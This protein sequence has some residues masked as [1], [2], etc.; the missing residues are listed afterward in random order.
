MFPVSVVNPIRKRAHFCNVLLPMNQ[1][2]YFFDFKRYVFFI[3]P[4]TVVLMFTKKT[5][6]PSQAHYSN[7]FS[8]QEN[9]FFYMNLNHG[10][11]P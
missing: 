4:G 2:N 10:N 1:K 3:N 8:F 11:Q 6:F 9:A 7:Q 5:P